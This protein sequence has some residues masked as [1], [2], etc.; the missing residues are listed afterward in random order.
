MPAFDSRLSESEIA[1]LAAFVS[2]A[3]DEGAP[4]GTASTSTGDETEADGQ[5]A[6]DGRTATDG[7]GAATGTPSASAGRQVFARAGC[8][9]CHTLAAAEAAG[10]VG[11]NLDQAKPSFA[12]VRGI[13]SSGSGAMPAFGSRLSEREIADLAAFVSQAAGGSTPDQ[14]GQGGSSGTSTKPV[15]LV[16]KDGRLT[17]RSR[18]VPAGRTTFSVRNVGE[19]GSWFAVLRVGRSSLVLLGK[20]TTIRSGQTGNLTLTL[21]KGTY[22]LTCCSQPG[23]LE[24]GMFSTLQVGS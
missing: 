2:Q 11:P 23:K 3:V 15:E 6:T 13:V 4:D 19:A 9:S 14:T 10:L 17:S 18:F 12:Q 5:T 24:R 8:G 22:L 7:N 21:S 16:L 1:D 20:L